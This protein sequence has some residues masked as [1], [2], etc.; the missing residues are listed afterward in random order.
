M[1]LLFTYYMCSGTAGSFP[2]MNPI[3]I[4]VHLKSNPKLSNHSRCY[5]EFDQHN[6][7][8]Q[9]SDKLWT[10]PYNNSQ[11]CP[12]P[13]LLQNNTIEPSCQHIVVQTWARA[14]GACMIKINFCN[15]EFSCVVTDHVHPCHVPFMP[16][17]AHH[18]WATRMARYTAISESRAAGNLRVQYLNYRCKSVFRR[19]R[20]SEST[21]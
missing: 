20:S 4:H 21:T 11:P 12:C 10:V 7:L 9:Y 2:G 14:G 19:D 6:W 3:A 17:L 13:K 16:V 15:R 8:K 5:Y 18:A 1:S